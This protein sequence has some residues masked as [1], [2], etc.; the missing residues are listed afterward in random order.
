MR[1]IKFIVLHCSDSDNPLHDNIN[2]IKEWHTLRGFTGPDG[3][4][5]NQDDVG[6]HWFIDKKG[7][8]HKGRDEQYV[9]AHVKNHNRFSIGVCFSGR[10]FKDF[11][12][13]QF[14]TGRDLII[15]LLKKYNLTKSDVILHRTL[16]PGKTCPNFTLSQ[17]WNEGK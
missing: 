14:N 4:K 16:D 17:F 11:H 5:G 15:D 12:T 8:L 13:D 7:A 10:T 6:Y 9:G 3:I 1:K 2:T